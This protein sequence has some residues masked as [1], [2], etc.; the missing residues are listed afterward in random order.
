MALPKPR[1]FAVA[2]AF[3]AAFLV[4]GVGCDNDSVVASPSAS[5]TTN[6]LYARLTDAAGKPVKGL[7]ATVAFV[8]SWSDSSVSHTSF[9]VDSTGVVKISGLDSG[10]YRVEAM[11][12]SLGASFRLLVLPDRKYQF[13]EIRVVRL[14]RVKGYVVLP[15][16]VQRAWIQVLGGSSG[17]WTDSL[18]Y[19][20]IPVAVGFAPVVLRA[21]I[22]QDSLPLGQDTLLLAPGEVRNLGLL[23]DPFRVGA[24]T[25]GPQP[26][27]YENPVMFS[28]A[29]GVEDVTIYYTT[30]GSEPGP[31]SRVFKSPIDIQKTTLVR[32]WGVKPGLRP[33]AQE[34]AW[35]RIRV[36]PVEF[37]P[38]SG[39]PLL[40]WM[41]STTNGSHVH[42]TTDGST[43][44]GESPTCD[45]IRVTKSFCVKAIAQMD[46]LED[47]RVDSL[48]FQGP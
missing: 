44:T 2:L 33:S 20:D 34:S 41:T 14:A 5:E 1:L 42:C 8:D 28:V 30:D 25:F 43:P 31:S 22:A 47:S 46:G 11:G 7:Y 32:A 4:A 3:F 16:G 48:C 37:H 15:Q 24:L 26:G 21:V 17:F 19:F 36:R 29:S 27:V 39:T 6:G 35:V 40:V 23:R 45:T 18:G 12:D 13:Q 10:E 38:L 9:R